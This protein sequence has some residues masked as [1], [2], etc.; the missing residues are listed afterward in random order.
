MMRFVGSVEYLADVDIG[1]VAAWIAAI[2]FEDWH[3]QHRL[4]DGQIR[5]AMMT[6]LGWHGFGAMVAPI[7]E[8]LMGH[9]PGCTPDQ[10]MLSVVMPG[11]S[12]EPHTDS[13]PPN[14]I[15]RVHVPLT[16]NPES[17][18]IVGGDAHHLEPGHAYKV[19]TLAVHSV[20]NDGTMPR[21]HFM[22]DVRR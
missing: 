21:T 7:V 9:F 6:D 3:Q 20:E 17:R 8:S 4:A 22:F 16:S 1:K 14:W 19:N 11:H 10:R 13:Q 5:P 12:I 2:P 15:C 18:F